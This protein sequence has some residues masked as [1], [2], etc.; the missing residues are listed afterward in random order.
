[1]F[2]ADLVPRSHDAALAKAERIFDGVG[3]N[4]AIYVNFVTMANGFVLGTVNP[5]GN[6]CLRVGRHFICNITST[7][8]PI[9]S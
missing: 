2:G 4:F 8:A 6:H 3:L 1:M 9:F 5:S 7:P